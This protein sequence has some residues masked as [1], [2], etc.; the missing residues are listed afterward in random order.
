[1]E[2]K[3]TLEEAVVQLLKEKGLRL[4][5]AESCTGGAIASRIV[6]V[7]GASEVLEQG[8]VTYSNEAKQRYLG[9]SEET[10]CPVRRCQHADRL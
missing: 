5:T 6:N 9:V 3:V 2:E 10:P 1:M 4:T 7:P 8:I